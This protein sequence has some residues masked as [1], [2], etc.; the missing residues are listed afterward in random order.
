MIH[1]HLYI[2]MHITSKIMWSQSSWIII[3]GPMLHHT[4]NKVSHAQTRCILKMS[5]SEAK[6]PKMWVSQTW[7]SRNPSSSDGLFNN[8][9]PTIFLQINLHIPLL[10]MTQCTATESSPFLHVHFHSNYILSLASGFIKGSHFCQRYLIW[11]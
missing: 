7:W 10:N 4:S 2:P 8:K 9:K 6:C 11:M 1:I 3:K 5:A